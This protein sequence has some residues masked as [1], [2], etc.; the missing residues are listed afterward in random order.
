MNR[1]PLRG[2]TAA[3]VE[4]F[5]RDGVVHLPGMLDQDWIER[6]RDAVDWH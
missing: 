1:K 5:E 2:I 3:E 6:M 4:S